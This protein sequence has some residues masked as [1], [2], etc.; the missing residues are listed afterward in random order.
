MKFSYIPIS[1]D[2]I[3]PGDRRRFAGF[4]KRHKIPFSVAGNP[5]EPDV[6]VLSQL[7]DL[8]KWVKKGR[9]QTKVIFDLCDAYLLETPGLKRSF[10]G[11]TKYMQGKTKFLHLSYTEL[12]KQTC[13]LADAVV[14]TTQA[15]KESIIPYCSNVHIIHDFQEEDTEV[16]KM[17]YSAGPGFS[18]VWE[19]MPFNITTF[20]M[21][22]KVLTEINKTTPVSLHLITDMEHSIHLGSHLMRSSKSIVRKTF[23]SFRNVYLYEWNRYMF[24]RIVTECDLAVI[25]M[26][27]HS[28]GLVSN[29][30]P[31]KLNLFWRMGMP[32]L[33]S[34][35][36]SYQQAMRDAEMDMLCDTEQEWHDKIRYYIANEGERRSAGIRGKAFVSEKHSDEAESERW[37][38]LFHSIGVDLHK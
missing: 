26:P 12:L 29:K 31:N 7:A 34:P 17:D 5:G 13:A 37:V 14:C 10:R 32:V 9:T 23:P 30:A 22:D 3:A 25:P 2:L 35:I 1:K 8:S 15:Q 19:G 36:P 33:A 6:V 38:Q 21:L 4:A 18:I 28:D 16:V 27:T 20:G 24:S 11:L